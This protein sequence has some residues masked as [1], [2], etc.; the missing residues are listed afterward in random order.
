MRAK[1]AERHGE[2]AGTG[3]DSRAQD[4]GHIFG[5]SLKFLRFCICSRP[6]FC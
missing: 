1:C 4:I 6:S 5:I 3:G 2:Q